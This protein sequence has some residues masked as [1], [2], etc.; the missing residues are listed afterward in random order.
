MAELIVSMDPWTL[1]I[2]RASEVLSGSWEDVG[3]LAH[4][5]EQEL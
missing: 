2:E 5:L 4:H 3:M 1:G